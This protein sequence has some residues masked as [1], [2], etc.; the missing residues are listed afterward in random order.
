MSHVTYSQANPSAPAPPVE[1]QQVTLEIYDRLP[2]HLLYKYS[3]RT[4]DNLAGV[5]GRERRRAVRQ[6]KGLSF[7]YSELNSGYMECWPAKVTF[8]SLVNI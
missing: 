6:K 5:V 4:K 3:M 2:S 8:E 1:A 7:E